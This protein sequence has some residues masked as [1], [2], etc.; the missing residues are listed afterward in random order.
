MCARDL[1]AAAD[2]NVPTAFVILVKA[3]EPDFIAAVTNELAGIK[4]AG[5]AAVK[6]RSATEYVSCVEK[7]T[8]MYSKAN[9]HASLSKVLGA[10]GGATHGCGPNW[11]SH[12]DLQG[13]DA[14][15]CPSDSNRLVSKIGNAISD[16]AGFL[17]E[18]LKLHAVDTL[19]L[20][21]VCEV[22]WRPQRDGAYDVTKKSDLCAKVRA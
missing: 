6:G 8:A 16:P 10:I 9:G 20:C 21:L 14:L 15:T 19:E 22:C 12:D 4:D 2:D 1:Q 18:Q 3:P 17:K 11:L 7:M 5:T 13:H